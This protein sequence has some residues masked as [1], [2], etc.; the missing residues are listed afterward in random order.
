M[1]FDYLSKLEHFN[2]LYD[3]CSVA[4][5]LVYSYPDSSAIKSLNGLDYIVKFVINAKT[6]S[7]PLK[8]DLYELLNSK[9]FT[10]FINNNEN[11]ASLHFIRKVGTMATR[12]E[13]VDKNMALIAL[14]NLYNFVGECLKKLT[15]IDSYPEF[16]KTQLKKVNADVKNNNF[17]TNVDSL[18]FNLYKNSI[19]KDSVLSYKPSLTEKETRKVYIDV[20]LEAVGWKVCQ[21][22]N[23]PVSGEAGIEIRVD[24]MPNNK[25]EGFCDYVLYDTDCK[26]L[27]IVEAKKQVLILLKDV[28][29]LYS[30]ES[31]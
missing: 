9:E 7:I 26:P 24:G 4:E 20:E 12:N 17:S 15:I 22:E 27:A 25:E 8:Y 28:N 30:M 2:T 11:M 19:P 21:K 5:E 1:N 14:E 3:C 29:K 18:E 16:D 31:V 13:K 6:G 23:V 10:S